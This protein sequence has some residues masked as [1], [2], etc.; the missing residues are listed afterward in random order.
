MAASNARYVRILGLTRATPYGISFWEAQVL[1]P[2]DVAA[3]MVEM[4]NDGS[5]YTFFYGAGVFRLST[6]DGKWNPLASDFGESYI[7][8]L[9]ADPKDPKHLV[10]VTEKSAVLESMDGGLTFE[11]FGQ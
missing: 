8:H 9:A 10:A 11:P 1:G 6:A 2:A 5:L 4:A 3:T 7:L